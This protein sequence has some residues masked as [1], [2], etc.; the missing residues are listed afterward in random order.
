ML[1]DE[2]GRVLHIARAPYT[3]DYPQSGWVEIDPACLL[4]SVKTTLQK[5]SDIVT[6]IPVSCGITNQRETTLIWDKATGEVIYPAIVWQDRRTKNDCSKLKS[7][8]AEC[9]IRERTG[10]CLDPYFSATKIRWVL[11]HVSGARARAKRGE[12]LFGTVDSFLLWHLSEEQVHAT[13]VTNASR[14]LLFNIHTLEWDAELLDLFDIPLCMLPEVKTCDA[15][16]GTLKFAKKSVPIHAVL[17]DQHSALVGQGC[18]QQGS[19]KATFGTGGFLMMNTG[20]QCVTSQSGLLT[21]I[22]FRLDGV[23]HYA[24]EGSIF[25]AGAIVKWLRN[26][27]GVVLEKNTLSPINHDGDAHGV[28]FVPALTGLGAPYWNADLRASF[29]GI[30]ANTTRSDLVTAAIQSV[31]YRT[32]DIVKALD[33]DGLS[34]K[35][36]VIDGGMVKSHFFCQLLSNILAHTTCVPPT[37]EATALGI[38]NIA[39]LGVGLTT[40]TDFGVNNKSATYSP[41]KADAFQYDYRRWRQLVEALLV[42]EVGLTG[43]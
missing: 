8:G 5:I 4:A 32:L 18:L 24:L 16:F 1:F 21:T 17:G 3:L 33:A 35:Q 2:Q 20:E 43:V 30:N 14:T 7:S 22:G 11:N 40:L 19:M 12:L 37:V 36:L 29:H 25:A 41:Y 39:G 31:A 42:D 27:L 26:A 23:V 9:I 38:A 10:L 6:E 34:I 15:Y 13:D 28:L